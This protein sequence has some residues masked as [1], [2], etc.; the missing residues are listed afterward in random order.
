MGG[1]FTFTQADADA[2]Q[3]LK[4]KIDRLNKLH[5]D[6]AEAPDVSTM[7]KQLVAS[8]RAERLTAGREISQLQSQIAQELPALVAKAPG[9]PTR[10]ELTQY[11]PADKAD[12]LL[13]MLNDA[14]GLT[15][16]ANS[17]VQQLTA[18]VRR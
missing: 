16:L 9:Q 14:G 13:S 11:T 6:L 2:A 18:S 8:L 5:D 17:A 4:Q 7:P 3:A 10:D 12:E 15:G 1:T